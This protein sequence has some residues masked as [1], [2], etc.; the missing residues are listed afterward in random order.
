VHAGRDQL[1]EYGYHERN[2]AFIF[3]QEHDAD[4]P[5]HRNPVRGGAALVAARVD[6]LTLSGRSRCVYHGRD[7]T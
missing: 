5:Y 6:L 3:R 2:C 4:R 1:I 7:S